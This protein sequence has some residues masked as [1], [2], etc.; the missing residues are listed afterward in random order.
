LMIVSTTAAL[1]SPRISTSSRWAHFTIHEDF[2]GSTWESPPMGLVELGS[3]W[4]SNTTMNSA[5]CNLP[6]VLKQT[7]QSQ[8]QKSTSQF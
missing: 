1:S 6:S 3:T 2:L 5:I 7:F 8:Q 4:P